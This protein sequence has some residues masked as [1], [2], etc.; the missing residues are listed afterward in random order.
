MSKSYVT[1]LLP[2]YLPSLINTSVLNSLSSQC[3][4]FN[5][6]NKQNRPSHPHVNKQTSTQKSHPESTALSL[7]KQQLEFPCPGMPSR[8][9]C[10]ARD[11]PAPRCPPG[12]NE[13]T[14]LLE[15]S[16]FSDGAEERSSGSQSRGC[17]KGLRGRLRVRLRVRLRGALHLFL[18]LL[19]W[20]MAW[21]V[22][23]ILAHGLGDA[24]FTWATFF[25]R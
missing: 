24:G 21:S 19:G 23:F 3:C 16:R 13:W 2:E 11:A 10:P 7:L 25:S 22:G 4:Q 17:K 6:L 14:V 20:V 18:G 8:L 5:P 1:V 9:H 15:I 12:V